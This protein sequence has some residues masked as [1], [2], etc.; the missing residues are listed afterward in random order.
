MDSPVA[1][2]AA[3]GGPSQLPGQPLMLLLPVL[4]GA[5]S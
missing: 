5:V 3:E 2:E 4:G 1:E